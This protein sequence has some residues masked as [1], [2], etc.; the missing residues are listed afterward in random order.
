MKRD[1]FS[2]VRHMICAA[3]LALLYHY[4]GV[5][6]GIVCVYEVVFVYGLLVFRVL[7]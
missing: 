4:G 3:R 7:W 5:V 1:G 2:C 6:R